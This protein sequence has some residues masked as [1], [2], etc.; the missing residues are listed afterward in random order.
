ML[1]Q[2]D[3]DDFLKGYGY[4]SHKLNKQLTSIKNFSKS[5][6]N[7]NLTDF[8]DVNHMSSDFLHKH[9]NTINDRLN[10]LKI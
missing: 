4:D 1:I 10:N 5:S 7:D 2:D 9:Q 8:V 3:D 6:L